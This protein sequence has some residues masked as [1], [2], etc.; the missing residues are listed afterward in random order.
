[1]KFY[2]GT[3]EER[4]SSYEAEEAVSFVPNTIPR[5]SVVYTMSVRKLF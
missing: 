4:E 5:P 2:Y 1:M 3:I